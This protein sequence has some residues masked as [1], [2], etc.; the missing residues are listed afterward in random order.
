M[1]HARARWDVWQRGFGLLCDVNGVF[2][3]YRKLA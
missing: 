1:K 2:Y 3:V